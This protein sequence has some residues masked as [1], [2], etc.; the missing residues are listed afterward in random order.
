MAVNTLE[1]FGD[2]KSHLSDLLDD[3]ETGSTAFYPEATRER[4][5]NA[6]YMRMYNKMA[7]LMDGQGPEIKTASL[8]LVADQETIGP[9]ESLPT[10][11]KKITSVYYRVD[12]KTH[13]PWYPDTPAN[14][15]IYINMLSQSDKMRF[16]SMRPT[17]SAGTRTDYMVVSPIPSASETAKIRLEYIPTCT[18]LD[19]DTDVPMVPLEH[20]EL[21]V[22]EALRRM[23]EKEKQ[24]MT[25][26][27]Y[28]TLEDLR[29]Q[30]WA[31]MESY[32]HGNQERVVSGEPD[33]GI[34]D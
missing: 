11:I 5:L 12:D 34:Y 21:I 3:S 2:L 9:S 4:M 30:F 19:E 27:A 15:A 22:Y 23:L 32:W 6:A 33:Y 13:I 1:T 14:R 20:R 29:T 17:L 31:D 25:Q 16:Y 10:D 28:S 18:E 8:D 24:N 7:E 26:L